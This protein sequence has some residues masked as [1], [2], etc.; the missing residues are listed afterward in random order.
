[1]IKNLDVMLLIG[2]CLFIG[3]ACA[4]RSKQGQT[5]A[6]SAGEN[7]S[8]VVSK[9]AQTQ[10][11]ET[12]RK[13]EE[14]F[15]VV[16]PS[17]LQETASSTQ[18]QPGAFQAQVPVTNQQSAELSPPQSGKE[19]VSLNFENADIRDVIKVVSEITKKNFIV[20]NGVEGAVTL[21]SEKPLLPE[22]VFDLFKSVLELNKL[23]LVQ[24]GEFYKIVKS[25]EAMK[26][27]TTVDAGGLPPKEDRLITQIV[28]LRYVRAKEVKDALGSMVSSEK[29]I[30]MYPDGN[31]DTLIITD[32]ASNIRKLLEIIE[33]MDVTQDADTVTE[34]FPIKYA[35]LTVLLND[36]YQ[37]L[38]LPGTAGTTGTTTPTPPSAAPQGDQQATPAQQPVSPVTPPENDES[39]K[40]IIRPGT[41]TKLYLIKQLNALLVST[42]TPEVLNAVKKWI[43]I[44][45]QP[46]QGIGSQDALKKAQHFIYPV[47]YQ[48]AEKLKS[49]LES[50]FTGKAP[51]VQPTQPDQQQPDQQQTQPQQETGNQENVP[52]FDADKDTNTIIITAT[53]Y[54]YAEIRDFL[55]EF[56]Q[57]PP[58]VLIDV[59]I[60]EVQLSDTD[61]FGVQGMLKGQDQVTVGGETN[62]IETTTETLF[63]SVFPSDGQGFRYV[64]AAP[65]RFLAQLRALA[66]ENKLKVLSAPHILVR[67]QQKATINVGERIPIK[68]V[69][70]TGDTA[71]E[72]VNYETTGIT[73][74]VTPTI[75]D[76]GGVMMD[77]TQ[78]V[79]D[80]GKESFGDTK[81]ASFVTRDSHTLV[82]TQDGYPMIIGGLIQNRDTDS[83][84]GV[85]LLKDIPVLG[86]I[87]RYTEKRNTRTE[88]VILVTPRVTKTAQ[89]GWKLT[90]S[91]LEKQISRLEDLFNRDDTDPD[92]VKN[93]IKRTIS[94]E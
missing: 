21:Y 93:F 46:T 66:T 16:N 15:G 50:V 13:I 37:I 57:Q 53:G 61:I 36:L 90:D 70:G 92:K 84:Q 74:E 7:P 30:V 31:G 81:A 9:E 44:L 91:I 58:Q 22:Q 83:R 73:L 80:V 29:S 40:E 75:N 35:D 65:G 12:V 51:T 82:V 4:S 56:D 34:I 10:R 69:T 71:K 68:T 20:D 60:A 18:P 85:P 89:E 38:S 63:S 41:K 47:K 11:D 17:V 6:S 78:K 88:L 76:E 25:E 3:F 59:L 79:S 77:I 19:G 67:S 48:D 87:F 33:R 27:Y 45:D 86:K 52:Q 54:K 1:M 26:R 39:M 24:I 43:D 23:A 14:F 5:S 49:L 62:S 2:Y 8:V 28:K 72:T 94:Q 32:L 64:L 42:N 55:R